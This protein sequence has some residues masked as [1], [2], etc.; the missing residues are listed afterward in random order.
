MITDKVLGSKLQTNALTNRRSR[1]GEL[2][3]FEFDVSGA[4]V[5]E[6]VV[7]LL[8]EPGFGGAAEDF[9]EADSHFGRDAAFAV[10]EFG[11]SGASDTEGGGGFGDGQAERFDTLAQDE[12]AWMWGILHRHGLFSFS[13]ML[14]RQAFRGGASMIVQIVDIKG[15]AFG[16]TKGHSPVSAD[17]DRPKAFHLTLEGM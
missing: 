8:G 9:G 14:S 4:E 10:D 1:S 17:G 16:E 15:I 13:A 12:A 2:E 7:G 6:V 11:E 3:A 5:G